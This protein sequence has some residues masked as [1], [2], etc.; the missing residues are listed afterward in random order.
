MKELLNIL[1]QEVELHEQLIAMLQKESEGFGRLRGSELLKLQGEKSR[2]VRAS[3]RLEKERIQ[4]VEQVADFWKMESKDLTLSVII[5][6][7]TEEYSLPLQQ[8]FDK[9][10]S[11]INQIHKIADENSL[12]ASGRLKSVES[13]IRFMSQLQNGPPTYSDAGKI[14]TATSTISRTEV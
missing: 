1:R 4:L 5:G 11:L 8:C 2:C 7:V 14:Q 12:Q 13:S 9:L 10:K 6:R 3:V